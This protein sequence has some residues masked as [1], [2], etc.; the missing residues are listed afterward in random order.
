MPLLEKKNTYRLMLV[1]LI[2]SMLFEILLCTALGAAEIPFSSTIR[3]VLS[4]I[5]FIRGFIDLTGI[6]ESSIIIITGLRL[7][8]VILAAAAGAALSV[9]GASFQGMFRNS[10]ADPYVIGSSSGGALGAAVAIVLKGNL[11]GFGGFGMVSAFAFMGAVAATYAVYMLGKMGSR[12][13]VTTL[14]L[15][16]IALNSIL[17][18]IL[19]LVLLFNKEQMNE[20]IFWTM[21]SFSSSGW[22]QVVI[23]LPFILIGI[24]IICVYSRDLNLM[25]L[26]E[27]SAQHL[28]VN[29]DRLKKI[30]LFTGAFITGLSVSVSGIIGFVG[31]IIPHIIRMIIGP[32]NRIMIP[33]TAVGGAMFLMGV[34][35]LSR[36]LIPPAEIPVGVLTAAVGGPFFIYLLIKSKKKLV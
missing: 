7:P 1:I 2:I 22:S 21:G 5:P 28:G 30:I 3:A 23:V 34:D 33:Y 35:S 25:L 6:K 11:G 10:L 15:S 8:R 24:G 29:T 4:K 20:I 16:G 17:S 36:I 14:I 32:D 12:I 19:S 26:G 31:I 27:E 13:S 18:S 9:T